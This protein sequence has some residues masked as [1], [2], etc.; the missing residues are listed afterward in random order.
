MFLL[1]ILFWFSAFLILYTYI[2]YPLLIALL[3]KAW[4][5]REEFFETSPQITVLIPAYNEEK[6]IAEKL[7]NTLQLDYP[8]DKL[9]ILVAADG[10]SD[11]TP[12]IVTSYASK[13]VEL[14]YIADR[15]G[16]M[17]AI[18]RA[19][20]FVRGEIVVLSDANNMYDKS[21]IRELILPFS[22]PKVGATT[23]AKLI[24]EDGRDLSSAEGLYWK[25]E[26]AIKNSESRIDSC[27]SS[28]GEILAIRRSVFAAPKEKI[29]ND[30][31]YIILDIL[32]RGYRVIYTPRARSFEYVSLTAGDEVERRTRM[33]AGLYQT[34]A[35]SGRLLPFR[36][37]LLV[38]Q[39]V[40]HKYFRAF[41]PFALLIMLFSNLLILLLQLEDSPATSTSTFKLLLTAQAVFYTLALIGNIFKLQGIMG[42]LLYL[43]V[44]L[45]NSNLATLKGFFSFVSN[46]QKHVWN[47]VRR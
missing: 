43:P 45:V 15:N 39:V 35:M 21:A 4:Q 30:D 16:K 6:Y 26:S 9:Q 5:K 38:W 18:I 31:H 13:G 2:G 32:R 7:E 46:K 25:Y 1:L 37:P 47:K 22:D 29:I 36:R 3:A 17:A 42:K 24:I 11:G 44:F 33:N 20:E 19:M 10:S 34:I 23:G 41:V 14:G 27:V 28:V 40:S 8:R 12:E